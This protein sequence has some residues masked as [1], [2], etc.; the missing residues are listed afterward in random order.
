MMDDERDRLLMCCACGVEFLWSAGEQEFFRARELSPP[1]RCRECRR[2]KRE[3][4]NAGR[5]RPLR[6]NYD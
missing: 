6:V 2:L 5:S 3:Q 1:R 4:V